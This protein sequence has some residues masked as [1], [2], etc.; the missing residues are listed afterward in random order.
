MV[1]EKAVLKWVYLKKSQKLIAEV[2]LQWIKVEY[3]FD[4]NTITI[5]GVQNC[6][7]DRYWT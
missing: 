2:G 1:F 7:L 5:F 6:E 4:R 3:E